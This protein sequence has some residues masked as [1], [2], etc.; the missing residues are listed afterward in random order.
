MTTMSHFNRLKWGEI[1]W[2][3]S[4]EIERKVDKGD[5]AKIATVDPLPNEYEDSDVE[6]G[7]SYTYRVKY[8]AENFSLYSNEVSKKLPDSLRR[9][10][11]K[12]K[13]FKP[14]YWSILSSQ[15]T[16]S[17]VTSSDDSSMKLSFTSRTDRG[18]AQLVWDS[19]DIRDHYGFAYTESTLYADVKLNFRLTI[20]G[21]IPDI[22][23]EQRGLVMVVRYRNSTTPKVVYIKNYATP[24]AGTTKTYDVELDFN[25]LKS[26]WNASTNVPNENIDHILFSVVSNSYTGTNLGEIEDGEYNALDF[27]SYSSG[28]VTFSSMA[29][30]GSNSDIEIGAIGVF[31]NSLGASTQYDMVWDLNP[32]RIIE[33]LKA[34]N[35]TGLM[36]HD[37]GSKM[38]PELVFNG[39]DFVTTDPMMTASG[40]LNQPARDWHDAF[41][42]DLR[43]NNFS[44][45][46]AIPMEL[47]YGRT[48]WAQ[49]LFNGNSGYTIGF[50]PSIVISPTNDNAKYF[51]RKAF[52]NFSDFLYNNG[53]PIKMAIRNPRWLIQN[54]TNKPCVYD[55]STV[56]KFVSQTGFTPIDLGDVYQ[57]LN[58]NDTASAAFKPWLQNTLGVFCQ[59][60]KTAV[61][62][63]YLT[64]QVSLSLY[65]ADI[66]TD[67]PS[68]VDQINYPVN[69]WK[70]PNFD[71]VTLN[72]FGWIN[73][74]NPQLIIAKER[75]GIA[76][77]KLGY[78]RTK[79]NYL[80]G[81]VPD[82]LMAY[83]EGFLPDT[84]Y[85]S[86]IWKRVFGDIKN[87]H[88]NAIDK[89]IVWS[90]S[91]VMENGLT[92]TDNLSFGYYLSDEY[93]EPYTDDERP[94]PDYILRLN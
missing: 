79:V 55:E 9:I 39:S 69:L 1:P 88:E 63:K 81:E 28:T 19:K 56:E 74:R 64:A 54:G 25:T 84:P 48:E 70:S 35:Y 8:V 94:Y 58:K 16:S 78:A 73:T 77:N 31:G 43:N 83:D 17:A 30:S 15:Y 49:K 32:K 80:A 23:D 90:Y 44:P 22:N 65:L 52:E 75:S 26:E 61:N 92:F 5:F 85:A 27:S 10:K 18:M 86:E 46:F 59:E 33:N 45:I 34:L 60:I 38:Y 93:Y 12:I 87:Q 68:I 51:L 14:I 62:Q 72:S 21:D 82:A 47:Y 36:Y 91:Q 67:D 40:A 11:N 66:F 4:V 6:L 42:R 3:R 20:T 37:C 53:L 71:F 13:K 7:K 89:F 29:I 50:N 41:A 57:A 76:I 24:V 2:L